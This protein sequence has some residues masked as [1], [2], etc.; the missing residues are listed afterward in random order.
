[1]N[2]EGFISKIETKLSIN[3]RLNPME[4]QAVISALRES[5]HCAQEPYYEVIYHDKYDNTEI[6]I[7]NPVDSK[8]TRMPSGELVQDDRFDLQFR[9]LIKKGGWE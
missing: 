7:M 3:E 1:M 9:R 4:I 8:I 2:K 6:R 5:N